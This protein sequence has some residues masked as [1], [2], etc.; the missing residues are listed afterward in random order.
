MVDR[1]EQA[2]YVS[3][4]PDPADRRRVVV[5]AVPERLAA[6]SALHDSLRA[7][8]REAVAAYDDDQLQAI[9][10]FLE[11]SI[12]VFRDEATRLRE[13]PPDEARSGGSSK[14]TQASSRSI[15]ASTPGS[16]ASAA[17]T[18]AQSAAGGK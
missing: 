11:S 3:R 15:A 17:T 9:A 18:F 4:S 12:D 16:A 13:P 1:L 5:A 7:A 14:R 8:Q 10:S 2:G 6:L